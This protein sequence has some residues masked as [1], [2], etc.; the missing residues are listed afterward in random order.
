MATLQQRLTRGDPSAFA[1]LYDTCAGRVGHYLAV[2]L[3]SRADADDALQET[4]L[5]LARNKR[6]LAKVDNLAAYVFA[7]ARNEAARLAK[8][9]ARRQREKTPLTGEDLFC[10]V[11]NDHDAELRE[12]A[13]TVAA[14]LAQLTPDLRE[15]V[16]LKTYGQLTFQQISVVTGLPQGTVATR[17]RS[18][19]MQMQEWCAR[20]SP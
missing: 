13:E 10:D 6:R 4:F 2:Y 19:V 8:R 11:S 18:A 16:E 1:E 7:V 17:Y 12:A 14:A 9:Q 5:R 3:G 20:Q 15:V